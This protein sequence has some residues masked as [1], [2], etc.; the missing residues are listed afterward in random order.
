MLGEVVELVPVEAGTDVVLDMYENVDGDVDL[1]DVVV[2]DLVVA[3]VADV[4]VDS[5]AAVIMDEVVLG[6]DKSSSDKLPFTF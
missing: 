4:D 2:V 1:D 5:V 3:V 6:K